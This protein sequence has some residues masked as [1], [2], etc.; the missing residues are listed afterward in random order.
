[1]PSTILTEIDF[2]GDQIG[3]LSLLVKC[4]LA[5]SNGEARK[6]VQ[7]GGI[8]LDGKKIADPKIMLTVSDFADSRVIKKG[9]K[10]YHKVQLR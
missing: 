4:G 6:L 8:S 5:A 10:T 1:M 7:G 3:I 2:S 9:K